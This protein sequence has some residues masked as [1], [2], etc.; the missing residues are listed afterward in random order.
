MKRW[1]SILLGLVV[2]T[3]LIG[4]FLHRA[5]KSP[6]VVDNSHV[7]TIKSQ[8]SVD[9]S[10]VKPVASDGSKNFDKSPRESILPPASILASLDLKSMHES[11][12]IARGRTIPETLNPSQV[13]D[14]IEY[15]RIYA[16]TH[17]P[18]SQFYGEF[19]E[20]LNI[21][22][23]QHTAEKER[24]AL[25]IE[26]VTQ[27]DD[28]TIRNYAMQ[29]IGAW[30]HKQPDLSVKSRLLAPIYDALDEIRHS[31]SGTALMALSIVAM[32]DE[33]IDR[34][35]IEAAAIRLI[36]DDAAHIG[37]RIS[38]LHAGTRLK[39]PSFAQLARD[40][41]MQKQ[42]VQFQIT[43]IGTLGELGSAGDVEGLKTLMKSDDPR[44]DP[45][46]EEALKKITIRH[47]L[48]EI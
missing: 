4:L 18:D 43:A 25:L 32:N 45:A 21:L 29:H 13:E 11:D 35:R 31:T 42:P 26:I 10:A 23:R 44:L 15:I 48:K 41:L 14:L 24:A 17:E 5:D 46:I 34:Q 38:A 1:F 7:E 9:I 3:A 36:Q 47:D 30:C 39:M 33:A 20:F 37:S 12:G 40:L 28:I 6:C 27:S 22:G 19:N 2:F 16:R 8:E